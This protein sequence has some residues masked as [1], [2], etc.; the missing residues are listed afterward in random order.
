MADDVAI[1]QKSIELEAEGKENGPAG[2]LFDAATSVVANILRIM[3]SNSENPDLAS[4][5]M[6]RNEFRKFYLWNCGFSTRSGELDNILSLSNNLRA[7]VLTLLVEW[8]MA[9]AKGTQYQIIY[10]QG[11]GLERAEREG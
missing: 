2:Y 10:F 9:L 5:E 4:Y 6:L 3:A 8:A 11:S 1:W 7:T